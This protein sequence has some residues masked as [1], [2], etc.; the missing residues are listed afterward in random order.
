MGTA[1]HQLADPE[2]PLDRIPDWQ[3]GNGD[4]IPDWQTGKRALE[5]ILS[6]V[7]HKRAW[8]ISMHIFMAISMDICM[9][10]SIDIFM[11]LSMDI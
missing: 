2:K 8:R 7:P 5:A 1:S 4:C 3:T 9:H 10:I 11:D 6:R